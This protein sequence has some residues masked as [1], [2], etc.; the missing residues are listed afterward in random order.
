MRPTLP[1]LV[2]LAAA[3][4]VVVALA[5]VG[6]PETARGDSAAPDTVTTTGHGSVSIVPDRAAVTAGVHAQARTAAAALAQSSAETNAVIAALKAHGGTNLQTQTVSLQPQTNEQGQVTGYTADDQVSAEAAIA[7]AGKLIDA[8]VAAGANTVDGP[9]LSA[10]DREGA[11]E[12]ALAEAVAN[13][14]DKARALGAAGGFGV[15]PVSS[16]TEESQAPQ[17]IAFGARTAKAAGTPV[18]AGT[19]EVAAD[20]TVAFRLQ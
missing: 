6:R 7:D 1:L 17:P 14:R 19:Q 20:V 18:E 10:S 12:R 2:A 9:S 16:V 3:V 15:G 5:G 8:A 4:A 11:Y 13:A